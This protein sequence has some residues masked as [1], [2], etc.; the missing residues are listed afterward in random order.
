TMVW[1]NPL[2]GSTWTPLGHAAPG[3]IGTMELLTDGTVMALSGGNYYKLTPDSTGS[4]VNGTWW[5]LGSPSPQR[6]Y[7][8]TNV[9]PDGR[10]FVLGGEY[11][12]P[13][14]TANWV[15]SGEIY[16]SVTNSWSSIPN[17]PF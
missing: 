12:G 17:F 16:N 9:L 5:Q 11:S 1:A 14:N 8:D 13:N 7:D 6:L 2:P 15:S 10:V 3:G 4:Y